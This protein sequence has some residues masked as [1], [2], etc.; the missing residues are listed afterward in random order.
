VG[1]QN[2]DFSKAPASGGSGIGVGLEIDNAY[3]D[4]TI[5]IGNHLVPNGGTAIVN[6]GTGTELAHNIT[7]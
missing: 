5:A 6:A 4:D 3:V 2:C 1:I 7:V